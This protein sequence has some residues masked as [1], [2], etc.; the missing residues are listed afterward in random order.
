MVQ[1]KVYYKRPSKNNWTKFMYFQ[2]SNFMQQ[3]S[4]TLTFQTIRFKT[5]HSSEPTTLYTIKYEISRV[6]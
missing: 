1:Y 6:V 4:F 3:F 2:N 5:T